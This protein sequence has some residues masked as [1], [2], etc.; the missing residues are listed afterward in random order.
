M[1]LICE[2]FHQHKNAPTHPKAKEHKANKETKMHHGNMMT[3]YKTCVLVSSSS[4]SIMYYYGTGL[5][6][7]GC[8]IVFFWWQKIQDDP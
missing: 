1:F 8:Q 4:A 3:R 5:W 6:N 2:D 7:G